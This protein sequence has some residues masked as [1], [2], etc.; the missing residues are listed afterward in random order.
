MPRHHPDR[1]ASSR[2]HASERMPDLTRAEDHVQPVLTH[3]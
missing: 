1:Q 3:Q 2:E